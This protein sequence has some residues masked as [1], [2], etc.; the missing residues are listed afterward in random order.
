M[1]GESLESAG[2]MLV[3]VGVAV[4][5]GVM[6]AAGVTTDEGVSTMV[7]GVTLG[8]M[9]VGAGL[10]FVGGSLEESG[11]ETEEDLG[12]RAA[13]DGGHDSEVH[14]D[15]RGKCVPASDLA[16]RAASLWDASDDL[17]QVEVAEAVSDERVAISQASIAKAVNEGAEA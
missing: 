14:P 2:E 9:A 13:T 1:N 5:G 3:G 6:L 7:V 15:H 8:V 16:R 10:I 12:G 17:S 4:F 11:D